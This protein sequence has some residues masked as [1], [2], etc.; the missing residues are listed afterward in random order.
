MDSTK[1]MGGCYKNGRFRKLNVATRDP[2]FI[3]AWKQGTLIAKINNGWI[4]KRT[5]MGGGISIVI[6][7]YFPN[8]YKSTRSGVIVSDNR[9]G[10]VLV[11]WVPVDFLQ[12]EIEESHL[13]RMTCPECSA[14][15][16]KK[17]KKRKG[18]KV[19]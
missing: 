18:A 12:E 11:L 3:K 17:I 4:K 9:Q 6:G 13:R 2:E 1:I 7:Q 15:R 16:L 10:K 14:K 5:E 19:F 8:G